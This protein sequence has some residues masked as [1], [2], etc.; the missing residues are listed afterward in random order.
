MPP[1]AKFTKEQ[2]IACALELVRKQG[3]DALTARGLAEELGSSPRPIFTLFSGMEEVMDGVLA[4]ARK[5]YG[6]YVRRG[7][8]QS[9]AFKGVGEQYIRFAGEE[10]MLFGLLFVRG[11]K[12]SPSIE[13]ILPIIEEHYSEILSSIRNDYRLSESA[14]SELY[15][16]LWIYTHGIAVLRRSGAC[17]LT[18]EEIS[19]M[20]TRVFTALIKQI[21]SEEEESNHD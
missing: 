7:L 17:S 4:A 1:K 11:Q 13:G 2:V 18:D 3:A 9:P 14:A 5:I 16:H 20:L 10:P 8:A 21:K 12:D 6:E 19:A 15:R